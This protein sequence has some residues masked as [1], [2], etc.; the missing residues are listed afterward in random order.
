VRLPSSLR[1][2]VALAAVAAVALAGVIAGALLVA[3]VERDGR[4]DVDRDL[5]ERAVA[6]ANNPLEGPPP[7]FPPR[8]GAGFRRP[9]PGPPPGDAL[10]AGAGTFVQVAVGDQV[11]RR[12]GDV[13]SGAPAVPRTTGLSTVEI[14]GESWRALT[15][16][17]GGAADARA[18]V[19]TT[20]AP[21]DKRAADIRN[22]VL[23][24]GLAS[25]A[26]TAL[27]AWALTGVAVRPLGRLRAGAA[28]VSGADDL[29]TR[30]PDDDGP[31]EVR[32]L[33][34]DLNEMLA[35]LERAVG[36]T[37]R[38]AADAGHEM[39]TP[40]TGMRANLDALER[41]PD[42]PADER[43]ALVRAMTAE[44]ERIVHL[45]EG[46]Q[47]LARGDAAA[48]LPREAVEL[49]DLAD[50]AV[51]AARRRH[52]QSA[53]ELEDQIGEAAVWGWPSGLRLVLDNLLDNAA[54]HGRPGGRI[55]VRLARDGD[56]VV[57]VE[58]DGPGI[59]EGERERLLEPFA[60]GHGAV[61]SGS[62]LG[63]AIVDQQA[64]LHGGS[65]TL[66]RSD[67][68]GGLSVAVRLPA[69]AGGQQPSGPQASP[70]DTTVS[71]GRSSQARASNLPRSSGG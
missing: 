43:Q 17:V 46:L 42:L 11:I 57:L 53:F 30:L 63:L 47:A 58:D 12:R 59:A 32:S 10:L 66:G 2:R 22:L 23:L 64:A 50:A 27:A 29:A 35:R 18:E 62:G 36:A 44:Q 33:A 34:R 55:R 9:P 3:A 4:R 52:A 54:L 13:P 7:G 8:A 51:Y 61:A 15:I 67:D 31:D 68:L 48:S 37:R 38:F 5:R 71:L 14:G 28:R 25:V 16:P 70:P 39:R 1:A 6:I 20:L 19:L 65:L 45:L 24:I 56:L 49:A 41:N 40:L 26:L 21:V 69:M 60:R